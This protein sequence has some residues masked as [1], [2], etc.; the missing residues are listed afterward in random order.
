M[1]YYW[2]FSRCYTFQNLRWTRPWYIYHRI[3]WFNYFSCAGH[4]WSKMVQN[5]WKCF[6]NERKKENG[7]CKWSWNLWISKET[8]FHA[9]YSLYY[10]QGSKW[11][12]IRSCN[13]QKGNE[14][15]ILQMIPTK[16]ADSAIYAMKWLTNI[17]SIEADF[18]EILCHFYLLV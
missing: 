7:R 12:H 10:N 15:L 13:N 3:V 17:D 5:T 6:F 2:F 8:T 18:R 9:C 11:E 4:K 14:H 1:L 16:T